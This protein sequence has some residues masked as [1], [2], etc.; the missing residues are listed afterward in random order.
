MTKYIPSLRYDLRPFPNA[1]SVCFFRNAI[2]Y[3]KN[4]ET[5]PYFFSKIGLLQDDRVCKELGIISNKFMENPWIGKKLF[6]PPTKENTNVNVHK[7]KKIH[8]Q[9]ILK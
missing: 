1:S 5:L 6:H 8:T 7:R 4:A 3:C 2:S 9:M